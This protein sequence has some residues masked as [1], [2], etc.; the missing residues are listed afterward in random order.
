MVPLPNVSHNHQQY[1][2]EVLEKVGAAKIIKNDELDSKNLNNAI[3]EILCKDNLEKM[4]EN[5]KKASVK[6]VTDKIYYEIQGLVKGK[7]NEQEKNK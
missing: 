4:S 7:S 6:D 1:N 2:A 3:Q 5:A